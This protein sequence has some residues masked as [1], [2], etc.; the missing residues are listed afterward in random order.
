MLCVLASKAEHRVRLHS[1]EA[2][3]RR[4]PPTS[5]ARR[6]TLHPLA[7]IVLCCNLYQIGQAS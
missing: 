3:C 2:G 5:E 4:R 6:N 7:I 1:A